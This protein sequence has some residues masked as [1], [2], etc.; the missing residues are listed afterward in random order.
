L[1]DNGVECGASG[2][3]ERI[4]KPHNAWVG[5]DPV[6]GGDVLH[7]VGMVNLRVLCQQAVHARDAD[8]GAD[9]ARQ[10]VKTGAFRPLLV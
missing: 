3:G 2:C 7:D 4:S 10:T 5:E 1:R 6:Y 9:V 8:V